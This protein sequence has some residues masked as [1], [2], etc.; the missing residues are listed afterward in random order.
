MAKKTRAL[1]IG[2]SETE[3]A[4]ARAAGILV[5]AFEFAYTDR[6]IKKIPYDWVISH[7]DR[8]PKIS[9]A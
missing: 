1:M 8:L 6:P 9:D 7:F 2:D 3:I 4:N 5:I